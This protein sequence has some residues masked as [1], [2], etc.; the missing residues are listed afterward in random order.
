M[1]K[2]GIILFSLLWLLLGCM[3][4]PNDVNIY[5][6]AIGY[7]MPL[8]DS[9]YIV[10][11]YIHIYEHAENDSNSLYSLFGGDSPTSDLAEFPSRIIKFNDRYFCFIELDEP[12]LS[13]EQINQI[14]N[15]DSATVMSRTDINANIWFMGVSKYKNS[16]VVVKR[17][18][19]ADYLFDYTELWPYFS[20]GQPEN[21]D[22][23]MCLEDHD[24][25]LSDSSYLESDSLKFYIK[26]ICGRIY[27]KNKTD[28]TIVLSSDVL[29]RTFIIANGSDTLSLSLRDSLPIEIPTNGFEVLS[30]ES[31][32]NS[33]FY[34]KLPCK[35][36]WMSL[37]KILSDSTFSFLK[38]N[39]E[40]KTIRL[41]HKDSPTH[42]IRNDSGEI[43]KTFR[44]KG[45]F[46]KEKRNSRF[47]ATLLYS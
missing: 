39:G 27:V 25:I 35:N 2:K 42:Y 12:E 40:A 33:S 46:D 41:L 22:F 47:I 43:L 17:S 37:Y 10:D 3:H 15:C 45:V 18:P 20:G 6:R 32:E 24:M 21:P 9:G 16:G 11:K 26:K 5:Q 30:Y 1:R 13:V 31:S 34:Q 19:D 29:N 23:Y 28:S 44:N 8:V 4:K 7:V 14:T 36:T 38:I